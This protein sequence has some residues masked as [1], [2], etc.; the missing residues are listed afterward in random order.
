MRGQELRELGWAWR[1]SKRCPCAERGPSVLRSPGNRLWPLVQRLLRGSCRGSA[2][3]VSLLQC[4]EGA[5][6][7]SCRMRRHPGGGVI[8]PRGCPRARKLI[9]G[10]RAPLLGA[11]TTPQMGPGFRSLGGLRPLCG[12]PP[13]AEMSRVLSSG[14]PSKR[15]QNACLCLVALLWQR[16][17]DSPV[18]HCFRLRGSG[19]RGLT[20]CCAD[21]TSPR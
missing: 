8:C 14:H 21:S 11:G 13:A 7:V 5:V 20:T 12:P 9:S 17:L 6:T 16:L 1:N 18:S 10:S 3:V 19:M 4:R 15:H 2:R